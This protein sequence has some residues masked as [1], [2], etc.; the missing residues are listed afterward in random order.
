M[1]RSAFTII[2][3]LISIAVFVIITASA[4]PA[5]Q[6]FSKENSLI[7]AMSIVVSALAKAEALSRAVSSNTGWGIVI[8]TS[9]VVI[10][11]GS[12]F[13]SST[14]TLR[15]TIPLPSGVIVSGSSSFVFTKFYGVPQA[16]GA[17]TLSVSGAGTSTIT[18]NA[19]GLI[20]H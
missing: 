6:S 10:F 8:Q 1:Q 18:V 9:S 15:Q 11:N 17:I 19:K 3:L 12:L 7:E 20:S 5:Y 16:T 4:I 2:E 14:P 13:A